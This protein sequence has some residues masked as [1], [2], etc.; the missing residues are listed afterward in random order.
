MQG[1]PK[2]SCAGAVDADS[3]APVVRAALCAPLVLV[4]ALGGIAVELAV[5]VPAVVL[6]LVLA[7]PATTVPTMTATNNTFIIRT[8]TT[9]V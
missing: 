3:A 5:A 2:L 6:D 7:H 9:G 8:P 1:P 4:L